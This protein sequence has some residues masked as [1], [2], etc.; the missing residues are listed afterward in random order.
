MGCRW[1]W[2]WKSHGT[3]SP[4]LRAPRGMNATHTPLSPTVPLRPPGLMRR[5]C[6]ALSHQVCGNEVP[7]AAATGHSGPDTP[8]L[9]VRT[10]LAC[11]VPDD[12]PPGSGSDPRGRAPHLPL[13]ALME[14]VHAGRQRALGSYQAGCLPPE[15][16][17]W[18]E[19]RW[20]G[21]RAQWEQ[22]AGPELS[23][24][25]PVSA[26]QHFTTTTMRHSRGPSASMS[27]S[28]LPRNHLHRQ[29][30]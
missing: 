13:C 7:H 22:Q 1:P 24:P 30:Y 23:C 26:C 9:A 18:W 16:L 15:I 17:E 20:G 25:W 12:S 29:L 2:S 19:G 21:V 11:Y 10:V 6:D 8:A 27:P 14:T 3:G 5:A 4:A 28:H